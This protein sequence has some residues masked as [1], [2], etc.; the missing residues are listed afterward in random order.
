MP[1]VRGFAEDDGHM[2]DRRSARSDAEMGGEHGTIAFH[3]FTGGAFVARGRLLLT[4]HR[5]RP[6][7]TRACQR[8]GRLPSG[9]DGDAF[10]SIGDHNG[11]KNGRGDLAYS[12]RL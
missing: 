4:D 12:L 11:H 8:P 7:W 2:Y 3:D 10:E 6:V 9:P 1:R 5:H